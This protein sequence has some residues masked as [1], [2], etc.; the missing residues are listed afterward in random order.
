MK[1]LFCLGNGDPPCSCCSFK[2]WSNERMMVYF[3]L[4]MVRCSLMMVKCSLMMVNWVYDHSL[5]SPSLSS[6]SPSLT[7]IFPSL[8]WSI[9]SFAHSTII[10]KLHQ[11]LW[12]PHPYL[13]LATCKYFVMLPNREVRRAKKNRSWKYS[14]L[15]HKHNLIYEHFLNGPGIDRI[16]TI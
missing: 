13:S 7:S 1:A 4:M 16:K 2:W 9:P 15:F 5:I 10:E 6:S 3:K 12:A 8:A 11:L 14:P